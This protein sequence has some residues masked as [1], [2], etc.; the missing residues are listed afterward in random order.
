MMKKPIKKVRKYLS[1]KNKTTKD[2]KKFWDIIGK[3]EYKRK[4]TEFVREHDVDNKQHQYHI[5]KL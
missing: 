3:R 5:D 4:G 1:S 2:N